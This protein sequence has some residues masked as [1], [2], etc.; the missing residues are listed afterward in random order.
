MKRLFY[1]LFIM[2]TGILAPFQVLAQDISLD[3]ERKGMIASMME[4]DE[5]KVL[6]LVGAMMIILIV[7]LIVMLVL[8]G[9]TAQILLGR[10]LQAQGKESQSVDFITQLK[11]RWVTGKL[12][13][14]GQEG[15]MLLDHNYDGI[16]EMDYSMPPWLRYVFIGTFIFA[17]FYV[18]AYMYFDLVPDQ[19]SEYKAEIQEAALMAELRAKAGLMSITAETAEEMDDEETIMAGKTIFEKSCAVCHAPDG[20]GGVG[21]NLTDEYWLHGNDIKGVFTTVSEGVPQKGMVPWKGKLS[22]KEIQDVA[23][24]VISLAG[25]TPAKPKEPQG[26]KIEMP[27]ETSEE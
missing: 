5:G 4:T 12:K 11:Q 3:V 24:F 7:L 25:T 21:P 15:D 17:V 22:P 2:T 13:P 20:G 1:I 16:K 8:L 19:K 18:P 6:L 10:N 27:I 9:V 23:N 14:V 26:N